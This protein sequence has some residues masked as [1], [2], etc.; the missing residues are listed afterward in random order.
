[1]LAT[2]LDYHGSL[3]PQLLGTN[4]SR[5]KQIAKP[6]LNGIVLHHLP[7]C[8]FNIASEQRRRM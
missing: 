2:S 3:N 5:G 6:K 8:G 1:M 4:L 7:I